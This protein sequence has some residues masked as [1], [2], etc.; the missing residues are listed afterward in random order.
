[1]QTEGIHQKNLRRTSSSIGR[2]V[3]HPRFAATRRERATAITIIATRFLTCNVRVAAVVRRAMLCGMRSSEFDPPPS[4]PYIPMTIAG[5]QPIFEIYTRRPRFFNS[6]NS[7]LF[8]A[9]RCSSSAACGTPLAHG[10]GRMGRCTLWGRSRD[11]I[12]RAQNKVAAAV[13]AAPRSPDSMCPSPLMFDA[14]PAA[15][16]DGTRS[17]TTS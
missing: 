13:A 15:A 4:P 6:S 10:W 1:M 5:I 16:H 9:P 2:F 12:T 7:G 8:L 14:S 3:I 17:T 11:Q